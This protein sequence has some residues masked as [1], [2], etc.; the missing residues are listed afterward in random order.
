MM[1]DLRAGSIVSQ[2]P[3]ST[4]L[5]V[6]YLRENRVKHELHWKI[7]IVLVSC[8]LPASSCQLLITSNEKIVRMMRKFLLLSNDWNRNC[9]DILNNDYKNPENVFFSENNEYNFLSILYVSLFKK[10]FSFSRLAT[11]SYSCIVWNIHQVTS[12]RDLICGCVFNRYHWALSLLSFFI[13]FQ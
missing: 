5:L 12:I 6:K 10:T 11:V 2:T 3:K 7:N 13:V 9:S 4:S 1:E 8:L